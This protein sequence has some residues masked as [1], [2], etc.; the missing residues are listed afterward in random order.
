MKKWLN[1]T[2]SIAGVILFLILLFI[3]FSIVI[4]IIFGII[5]IW[6]LISLIPRKKKKTYHSLTELCNEICG[7]NYQCS[8]DPYCPL[9]DP[10]SKHYKKDLLIKKEKW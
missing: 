6:G 2:L 8:E 5:L 3:G 4:I 1:N 9:H 7:K 10:K